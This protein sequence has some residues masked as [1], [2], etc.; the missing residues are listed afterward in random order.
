LKI[1]KN[2]TYTPQINAITTSRWRGE[3]LLLS[4]LRSLHIVTMR[5]PVL[6][7]ME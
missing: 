5:K 1:N 3:R 7:I 2:A 4:E 6:V